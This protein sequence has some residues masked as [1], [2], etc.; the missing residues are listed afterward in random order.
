M[1][2]S[3]PVTLRS[4]TP[5][6]AREAVHHALPAIRSMM[7]DGTFKRHDIAIF[8]VDPESGDLL[9]SEMLGSVKDYEHPYQLYG[10]NKAKFSAEHRVNGGWALSQ[11]PELV[12]EEIKVNG[13]F[14]PGGVYICCDG[15]HLA[16]GTSGGQ[17]ELDE[18]I[19]RMIGYVAIG[20]A[21]L[22][23]HPSPW[24]EASQTG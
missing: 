19:S 18:A 24:G 7:N 1:E 5:E 11:K 8:L 17:A 2:S 10:V 15:F 21:K 9:H 14:Y 12:S 16:V 20:L 23:G 22:G 3:A 4:I 6:V 13:A